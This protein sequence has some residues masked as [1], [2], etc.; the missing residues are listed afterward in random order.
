LAEEDGLKLILVSLTC[1]DGSPGRIVT[2][3]D[4]SVIVQKWVGRKWVTDRKRVAGPTKAEPVGDET[5]TGF[6]VPQAAD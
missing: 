6:Q 4:G 3:P 2:Y 1:V 5:L